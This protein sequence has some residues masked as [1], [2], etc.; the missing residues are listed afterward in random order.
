[1]ALRDHRFLKGFRGQIAGH[2]LLQDENAQIEIK[3]DYGFM[4]GIVKDVISNPYE[5]LSRKLDGTDHSLK[6]VLSGKIK[7]EISIGNKPPEPF[8]YSANIENSEL[9]ETMPINSI[10]A[11]IVDGY[12]ARDTGKYV[13]CYPFFPPHIS[14]PL[15]PGEYVWIVTETIGDL[16]YYYWFCRK[17]APIQIDDINFT[18]FERIPAINDLLSVKEKDN[19]TDYPL[20]DAYSLDEVTDRYNNQIKGTAEGGTNFPEPLSDLFKNSYAFNKEFTGEPTPRMTK[21]C[22]DLLLQGS[23]NAGLQI[24]TEK[25]MPTTQP[26]GPYTL[27]NDVKVNDKPN[28][29]A[30]DIF[31][32]RKKSSRAAIGFSGR[33]TFLDDK[34]EKTEKMNFA[35]NNS[36]DSIFDFIENDKIADIRLGDPDVYQSELNDNA[37]DATDIAARLYL[38]HDSSPDI[39]F[40]SAF[41][42]LTPYSG[43]SIVSYANHNRIVGDIDARMVSIQ[44]ESFVD[45]DPH[46][47][48]VIKSSIN[49]GQQFL[50]L[51]NQ[52]ITRLQARKEMHLA[53]RGGGE[54]PDEP[55]ILYSKLAPILKKM[56][57]DI[58][59]LNQVIEILLNALSAIPPIGAFKNAIDGA[60]QSAQ[61]AGPITIQ[62]PEYTDDDG[63]TFPADT[64]SVPTEL[65]GN[66][67]NNGNFTSELSSPVDNDIKS[68]KIFGE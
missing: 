67:I 52:G 68:T 64:I 6:D 65:L 51:S 13:I 10:F 31:V 35:A 57:G 12:H 38:S 15:K 14:L 36:E 33:G 18:N 25:F 46:G 49:G 63:N 39:I 34:R 54:K 62:I 44:G 60:R 7:P 32:G 3:S 53:V 59:F 22:G 56:G 41:D 19:Q 20:N 61:Q 45:L 1:M 66:N 4:T 29:A 23:N 48:V 9:I 47:N 8:D 17:V 58:A 55:F 43:E 21:D 24:T 37:L 11:Y 50:S 26:L 16:K 42:V 40:G 27:G 5:Y 28:S 30:V 2:D